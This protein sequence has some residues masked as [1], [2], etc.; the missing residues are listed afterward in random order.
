MNDGTGAEPT[1]R[2]TI[3]RQVA[4]LVLNRPERKNAIN[5][6]M[7]VE[8]RGALKTIAGG[9]VRVVVLSGAGGA[10]CAGQ[11]LAERAAMLVE[12]EVDLARSLQENYNPLLRA[13]SALPMP[14]IASV[15]GVAAGAGA[16]LALAADIVL[17]ARSARFQLAF[18]R[19]ALGPDSGVSWTLP[20]LIG[21]ARAM[22]MALTAD[23]ID[24]V[25]AES[26][27]LIWQAVEDAALE[28][29]TEALVQRLLQGP[30]NALRA[31]K[32]RMRESAD[33]SFDAALDAERD[34]QGV[35]GKHPDY[36]EAVTAFMAKRSPK[37]Q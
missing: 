36:R 28:N 10:F 19:V 15:S 3:D 26:W 31:I 33:E 23:M 30:Q 2:L 14:V 9:D 22:G 8:L 37:F 12:G 27:G 11:D 21:N 7:H 1:V 29:E 32:R 17:A 5:G 6:A 25:R 13:L 34:T 16:A 35:L 4:R 24:A 18:A 20:R